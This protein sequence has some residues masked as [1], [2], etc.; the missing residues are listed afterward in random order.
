MLLAEPR[1]GGFVEYKLTL[2]IIVFKIR[3]Q[4]SINFQKRSATFALR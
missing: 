4:L 3:T 1:P 2:G